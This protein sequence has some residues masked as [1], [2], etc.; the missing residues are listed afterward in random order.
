M[1][2]H[3]PRLRFRHMLDYAREAENYARG[4]IR[5]DL[6]RDRPLMHSLVRCLEVIG[7]AAGRI[8]REDRERYP[9]LSWPDL[10]GLRNRLIHAYD[11]VDL[12]ILWQ[13]VVKDLP[14]LRA[15]LEIIVLD[16]D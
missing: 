4:K 13:I 1:S 10:I 11:Q 5:E 16:F 12:D 14:P 3:D 2:K 9:D 6:D 8:P 7:E 15:R